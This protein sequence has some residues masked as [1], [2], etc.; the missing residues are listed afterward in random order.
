M[1][2]RCST[3]VLLRS[4]NGAARWR[5][6]NRVVILPV[7]DLDMPLPLSLVRRNDNS[8]P[9]LARFVVDVRFLPAVRW[10]VR[11]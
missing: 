3:S 4:P 7:I 8:S 2:K 1:P 6:P 9:L 11:H 5:C 10:L